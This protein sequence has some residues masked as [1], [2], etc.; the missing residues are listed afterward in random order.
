MV[1]PRNQTAGQQIRNRLLEKLTNPAIFQPNQ[2]KDRPTC[3]KVQE[4]D[5]V[6]LQNQAFKH[7]TLRDDTFLQSAR[8]SIG[9]YD[10]RA[11]QLPNQRIPEDLMAMIQAKQTMDRQTTR[12]KILLEQ[13]SLM[14]P[15]AKSR[16]KKAEKT[17]PFEV[18]NILLKGSQFSTQQTEVRVL[19]PSEDHRNAA[20]RNSRSSGKQDT[21]CKSFSNR[22]V[23]QVDSMRYLINFPD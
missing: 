13:K 3:S 2:I 20:V 10:V 4:L 18:E 12:E 9:G 14:T 7:L 21:L 19:E 1:S 23:N 17:K 15:N 16:F 6:Y 8:Q 11:S 22:S 5:I